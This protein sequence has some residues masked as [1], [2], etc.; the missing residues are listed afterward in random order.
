M[1]GRDIELE[2]SALPLAEQAPVNTPGSA[3]T[4]MTEETPEEKLRRIRASIAS[5]ALA[6][7]FKSNNDPQ[8]ERTTKKALIDS[9]KPIISREPSPATGLA[10]LTA[11]YAYSL[12]SNNLSITKQEP[13]PKPNL[14]IMS[15]LSFSEMF[16]KLHSSEQ[17]VYKTLVTDCMSG[18]FS[19]KL[20]KYTSAQTNCM[21][22][23]GERISF[24]EWFD[25]I[26]NPNRDLLSPPPG[27]IGI[28]LPYAMGAYQNFR[29]GHTLLEIRAYSE[30]DLTSER[31]VT[32]DNFCQFIENEAK[33]FFSLQQ[34]RGG[35]DENQ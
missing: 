11:Y 31:Y 17:E 8:L 6:R 16:Q 25:S 12:F 29:R 35:N 28:D 32:I 13:G 18:Y 22:D 27:C 3:S 21:I 19:N 34:T 2:S 23:E 30:R 10:L 7:I 9:C 4:I 14:G 1:S 15:R 24:K 33:W 5:R 20:V 26:L